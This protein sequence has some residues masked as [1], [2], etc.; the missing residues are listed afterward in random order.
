MV[1]RIEP[2]LAAAFI[3]S[4]DSIRK[5][6]VASTGVVAS[7]LCFPYRN[8]AYSIFYFSLLFSCLYWSTR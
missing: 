5:D 7:Y 8:D 4:F 3:G 6:Q 2:V 1:K